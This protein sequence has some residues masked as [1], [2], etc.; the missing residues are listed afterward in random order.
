[1]KTTHSTFNNSK[2]SQGKGAGNFGVIEDSKFN[3]D[4]DSKSHRS[5]I[6][7]HQVISASMKN[8][9]YEVSDDIN[10][11]N[12]KV[13]GSHHFYDYPQGKFEPQ[14]II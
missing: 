7:F 1:M 4:T 2:I 13:I 12:V 11:D 6:L 8:C 10:Y 14:G 5:T 9:E 3:T